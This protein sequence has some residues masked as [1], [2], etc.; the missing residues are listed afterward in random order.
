MS[1]KRYWTITRVVTCFIAIVLT[2]IVISCGASLFIGGGTIFFFNKLLDI[3]KPSS[4]ISLPKQK[5]PPTP[6]GVASGIPIGLSPPKQEEQPAA[7]KSDK[8]NFLVYKVALKSGKEIVASEAKRD[9]QWV[10]L[11]TKGGLYMEISLRDVDHI[12][13]INKQ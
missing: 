3:G 13:K 12:Q 1:E 5:S 10:K 2:M 11:V 6:A 4:P 9:G 8:F 7:A